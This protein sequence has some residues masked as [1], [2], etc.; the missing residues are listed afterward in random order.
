MPRQKII[1]Q[2]AEAIILLHK[3]NIIKRRIEKSYRYPELDEKIRK[4]RTRKEAKLLDK[5]DK[6]I[7]VPKVLKVDEQNKE[8]IMQYINGAK[9]S[10]KLDDLDPEQAEKVCMQIGKSIALLHNNNIIHGD[11]TT[12]NTILKSNQVFFI[13]FGL[14]FTSQ[15]IED[16]AVDLH[17]IRQALEAKH[18]TNWKKFF[19]LITQAY[20]EN[21]PDAKLIL[22][23]LEVVESRGRYKH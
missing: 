10:E 7:K 1:Q 16:K 23:R 9:L 15:R 2:G 18:F 20:K 5:A 17:L 22:E 19:K 6:L 11:L 8:I 4:S 12:S 3:D 13:D 21:S 14:G